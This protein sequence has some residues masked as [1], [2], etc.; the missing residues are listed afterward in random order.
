MNRTELV[1]QHTSC[2][3]QNAAS[4]RAKFTRAEL[5][6]QCQR[7]IAIVQGAPRFFYVAG[8]GRVDMIQL[9]ILKSIYCR[10]AHPHSNATKSELPPTL[11]RHQLS[12][13]DAI[14]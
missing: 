1:Q 10:V 4:I 8:G 11:F 7:T 13:Q 2:S 5:P 12:W 3:I 6:V 9:I 14:L